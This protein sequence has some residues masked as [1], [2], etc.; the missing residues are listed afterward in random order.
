M[1]S[2]RTARLRL[3]H[4]YQEL[5]KE[6]HEE[7]KVFFKENDIMNWTFE[8]RGPPGT[9]YENGVFK[10]DIKFPTSYP[11]SPPIVTFASR[12]FHPN[13]GQTGRVCMNIL[14]LPSNSQDSDTCWLPTL[15]VEKVLLSLS[16]L[17]AEPNPSS[18]LNQTAARLLLSDR[19]EY[20]RRVRITVE[21]S[22]NKHP[23]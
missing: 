5:Q 12:M 22:L 1:M 21:E 13:I 20:D 16:C 9:I 23:S 15:T 7:F 8:M 2:E 10:G 14:H 19:D 4:E 3:Q 6:K 17:L 11:F 18:S